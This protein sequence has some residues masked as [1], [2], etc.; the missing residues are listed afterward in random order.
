MQKVEDKPQIH[1][2][3][4]GIYFANSDACF[5]DGEIGKLLYRGYNI[6]DL[7]EQATFEEIAYLLFY[8]HL[9]TPSELKAFDAELKASRTLPAPVIDVIRVVQKAHPMDVLRS[10]VSA[11]AAFDPDTEIRF[12]RGNPQPFLDATLRKGIRLTAQVPTIVAAHHRI[13]SGQ[14][15]VAPRNDLNHAAN[16]LYMLFGK[17]PDPSEAQLINVDLVLHAEHGSNASSFAARVAASTLADLHCAIVAGIGTLKGPSHGGAAEAVMQMCLEIGDPERVPSYLEDRLNRGERVM[18]FG[19]RVYRAE[20]PRARHLRERSRELGI[21]KGQPHW[22]QMLQLIEKRMERYQS[23]GIFVN[24]DFYAGS[25]YYLLG[26]PEDLFV[27]MF[28]IGRTPG[29]A[30]QALEHYQGG[31]LLRPL[32]W[33]TGPMDVPYVPLQQRG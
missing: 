22:F 4:K 12:E 5:I 31:D 28:A 23:R 20:D 1:D 6:H 9:P 2:G 19:H 17:E 30:L 7:A 14:Q 3:L 25:I 33:Y 16:F 32:T 29:W 11:L 15:P 24:V 13:R 27:P 26:I 18:G 21:K 8:K 10:G